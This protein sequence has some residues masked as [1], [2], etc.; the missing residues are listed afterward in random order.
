MTFVDGL[1]SGLDTTTIINQ[2]MAIERRPQVAL[3]TQRDQEQAAS[4]ELS[5]IR[6]DVNA[7]RDLAADLRLNSSLQ[8]ITA[9]S[10]NPEAVSVLATTATTTGTYT[11]DVSSVA[12]AASMYSTATFASLDDVVTTP[13]ADVFQASGYS[14]LGFSDLSGSGFATGPIS[15]EVT[16]DSA[17]AT[18]TGAS[19]PLGPFT[20]DGTND[21][22]NVTVSGSSYTLTLA[23]GSYSDHTALTT[24]VSDAIDA[25]GSLD[26]VLT[27]VADDGISAVSLVSVDE[28]SSHS[29][30]VTGGSAAGELGFTIGSLASGT[31]GI[32]EVDGL[33]TTVTDVSDGTVVALPSGSAGSISA[34][35]SG[36]LRTGTATVAYEPTDG[37]SLA[38]L[39]SEVNSAD[40]GYTAMA[41]DTGSGYRLQLTADE[42]GAASAFTPDAGIFEGMAFTQLSN[43]SDAEL[44]VNGLN[45]FTVTSTDNTFDSILPGVTITVHD[46]TAA[47]VTVTTDRDVDGVA[48]K[49]GEVVTKMNELLTRISDSTRND[50]EGERTVLQGNR[51]ARRSADLLRNSLFEAMD[52]HPLTSVG[53]VGIELTREGAITFNAEEFKQ[54]LISQPADVQSLLIDP[55]GGIDEATAA[56]GAIDR[57]ITMAE[58]LTATGEGM[59][60]TAA[61]SASQRVEDFG[62]QIEAFERRLELREENLRRTYANLEVA[63]GGLRDQSAYLASQLPTLQG[64]SNQ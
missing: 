51:E 7:L 29:V 12:T 63:L 22:L 9:T 6:S 57:M 61:E 52:D 23:H 28:G 56:P 21:T 30:S 2:L 10:S 1:I 15:F 20:I 38:E 35:I 4:T 16:Q 5:A 11:F 19:R 45:P 59:L 37:G 18:L 27:A 49:V 43:G 48:E 60:Y 14:G 62:R 54:A 31:D 47:P 13:G 36:G 24:A 41:I 8:G 53:L 32:V 42:T 26:G 55:T 33:A 3:Q 25:H 34:T 46:V 50:P 44:T 40:L 64:Q 39:V 58:Q 17:A